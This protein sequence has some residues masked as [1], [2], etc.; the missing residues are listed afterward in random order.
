MVVAV[1][2]VRVVQ[3]SVDDVVDVVPVLNRFVSAA[4]SM[5]MPI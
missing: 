4:R 1:L 2:A 5:D 3:P